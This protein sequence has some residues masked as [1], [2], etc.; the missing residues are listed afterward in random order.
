M[1]IVRVY[2]N[3]YYDMNDKGNSNNN[4]RK[5]NKISVNFR[6]FYLCDELK[7]R[8]LCRKK[9]KKKIENLRCIYLSR[10]FEVTPPRH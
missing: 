4:N 5:H 2:S 6:I 9:K 8:Q 7:K 3:N 10:T 1:V